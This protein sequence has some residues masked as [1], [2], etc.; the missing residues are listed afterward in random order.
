MMT[1]PNDTEFKV[2]LVFLIRK[3]EYIC[4][5]CVCNKK[6]QNACAHLL[7]KNIAEH[8]LSVVVFEASMHSPTSPF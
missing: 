8:M 7:L 3:W 1:I 2:G 5:Y 4:V 6:F